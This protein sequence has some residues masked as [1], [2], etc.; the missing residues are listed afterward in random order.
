MNGVLFIN[1]PK[2]YTSRE[3]VNKIAKI[4]HTKKVGHTGTLD[5]L[6]TGVLIIC[7]GSYTKLV[8]H[9]TSHQKEYIATMRLGVSTDTLDITGSITKEQEG[10]PSPKKIKKIFNEFPREYNQEVPAYSAIKVNGKKL[11]EYARAGIEISLP[12]K[13]VTIFSLEI[14]SIKN[15]EITFKTT[16][17][18]GTYIRSLIRDLGAALST[19]AIMADL[20]RTKQGNVCLSHCMNLEDIKEFTPLKKID[21]LFT[22]PHYEI[23][24]EELKKVNNGNTLELNSQEKYLIITYQKQSLALYE[25]I[26]LNI[27]KIIFKDAL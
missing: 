11:Y 14:L 7:L 4:Y 3:V 16:V 15:K 27:Y 13:K 19:C 8:E 2:G 1:K 22:Y 10:N 18:K 12:K 24:K 5:P 6:A 25:Q 20:K 26:K 21:D 9:F 23:K 17:S